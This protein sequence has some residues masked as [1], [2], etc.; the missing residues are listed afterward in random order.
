MATWLELQ[1]IERTVI[2]AATRDVEGFAGSFEQYT[3]RAIKDVD[4]IARLVKH[5]FEKHGTIDLTELIRMGVVEGSGLVVVSVADAEGNIIGPSGQASPFNIEDREYFRLHAERDTGLPDISKPVVSRTSGR[6][7]ILLSRRMNHPNGS[8]AGIVLLTV[9]AEYFMEFY[10]EGDLDKQ[11]SLGLLGLDGIFRARSVGGK[12]TSV[13]DG[14][15]V[16][17]VARAKIDPVGHYE[18]RSD[19]DQVMRIVAYRKLPDYPFIV[20]AGRATEEAL[21][22]FYRNR[23]NYL[24]IASAAT[25]VILVFFA[26]ITVLAMRLQRRGDELKVQRRFLA[27]LVDNLPSGIAVRSVQPANFGQYVLW[28]EANARAF[29]RTAENAL[30]KTAED[31]MPAQNAMHVG[32]LD[33]QLLASP[34]VQDLVQVRDLPGRGRRMFHLIRAPIFGAEGQVE[35]IMTSATDITEEHAR[36]AELQLASKV[37]ETTADAIVMSDAD[38]R[39][40]MVNEAFSKLT[41]YDAQEIVGKILAESPFRPID[42][43]ESTAR[44]ERQKRDG[45]VTAEVSRFRKDGSPLSLW[46]TAS[47]VLNDDGTIRNFVRVFTDISLLKETQQKLEQLASFDTLTGLP[48]R[49]LLHDRLERALLRGARHQVSMALMF[50]DLDGFKEV[51][52]TLG[53]DVGDLLLREVAV[54]LATCIRA[55]DTIGRVGGDE[56]VIVLEDACL[57]ADAVRVCQRIEAALATPFDLDGHRLQT[58]ASVGIAIFP[59]D[60]TDAATLLKNADVAMYKAKRARRNRFKFFSDTDSPNEPVA[61]AD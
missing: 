17:L 10:Q 13:P 16:Q 42:V 35:Y 44:M 14:S 52:D 21:E 2:N 40:V 8:F 26:V 54:R 20:T 4:R 24:V 43:A 34:M 46:V 28:N 56:F 22:D 37:F 7:T 38:D 41:G 33:R 55:S 47:C 11:G 23:N 18:A 25:V 9:A 49:R 50:I 1:A 32:E 57:P 36:T 58:A 61:A 53:H 29:G 30:G 59:T 48:N 19:L 5:D 51:N 3:R 6:S 39:V 15:G 27:T 60:G 45:F 31:V 12:A